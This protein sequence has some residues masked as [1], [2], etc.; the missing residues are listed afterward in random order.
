MNSENEVNKTT[1]QYDSHIFFLLERY[2]LKRIGSKRKKKFHNNPVKR[3][4]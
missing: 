3:V 2:K 4:Q 1:N